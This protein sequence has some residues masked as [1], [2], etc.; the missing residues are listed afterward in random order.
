MSDDPE[1]SMLPFIGIIPPDVKKTCIA[2]G[3]INFGADYRHITILCMPR[4]QRCL[5]FLSYFLPVFLPVYDITWHRRAQSRYFNQREHR[6]HHPSVLLIILSTTEDNSIP[7][8]IP[9]STKHSNQL[10]RG[11]FQRILSAHSGYQSSARSQS[12][13]RQA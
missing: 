6:A 12:L 3:L 13:Q 8:A 7:P 9:V 2:A 10:T 4:K 5:A 11:L 1:K